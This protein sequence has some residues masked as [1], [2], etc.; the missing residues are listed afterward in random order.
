MLSFDG[1]PFSLWAPDRIFP[2]L[3][4]RGI[5]ALRRSERKSARK[6]ETISEWDRKILAR[7]NSIKK[8]ETNWALFKKVLVNWFDMEKIHMLPMHPSRGS[9]GNSGAQS[10]RAID[11]GMELLTGW[12][13]RKN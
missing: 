8:E 6:Q 4:Q 10:S 5:N 1:P 11:T 2:Y 13:D 12:S 9:D 7:L 3:A